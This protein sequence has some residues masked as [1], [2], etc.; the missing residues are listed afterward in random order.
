VT[1]SIVIGEESLALGLPR[2][3]LQTIQGESVVFV[4]NDEGFE[5]RDVTI[6]RQDA[7]MVEVLAGVVPGE[8]IAVENT[9]L[10]KAELG[11]GEAGHQH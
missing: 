11:K 1:T 2:S 8:R 7:A 4:R 6:G 9:F 5:R 3:A 10:L